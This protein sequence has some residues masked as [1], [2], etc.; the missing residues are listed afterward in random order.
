MLVTFTCVC[1]RTCSARVCSRGLHD[2]KD[3][4]DDED[5]EDDDNH[6]DDDD[7]RTTDGVSWGKNANSF[8][9]LPLS[10]RYG[11]AHEATWNGDSGFPE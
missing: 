8:L 7:E 11:N 9:C 2:D 10:L 6:D 5:D 3:D 4:D 1:S